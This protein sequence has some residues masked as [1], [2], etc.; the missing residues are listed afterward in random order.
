L[1]RPHI[2]LSA[3]FLMTVLFS[4]PARAEQGETFS[5]TRYEDL[6]SP[7][8]TV[9]DRTV[10]LTPGGL[11]RF[12]SSAESWTV[13]TPGEGLPAEP[14]IGL[15]PTE[16]DLW[17][18]GLGAS[19]SDP[20]FDDWQPYVPDTDY[21]GRFVYDIE[22]DDDYAY[23][24]T[25]AGAARFDRYIL[26]W[27]P[28]A[29]PAERSLGLIYDVAVGEERVWF[30]LE[31]GVAEYRKN[32]ENIRIDTQ[33]GQLT[34]PTVLALRQT[35]S[36]IWAITNEGLARYN[37][38]LETWTSFLPGIDLPDARIH[39]LTLIGQ[40][41]WLGTDDGLWRFSSDT[42][43]WRRDDRC[44]DM[45]GRQV[46][47]FDVKND[48]WAVTDKAFAFYDKGAERWV[49]F[50]ENVSVEPGPDVKLMHQ[51][52]TLFIVTAR[53]ITYA[54]T[55]RENNPTLFIYRTES[56]R[57][58]GVA[59]TPTA[60][61]WRPGLYDSGLGLQKSPDEYLLLKGGVTY[62]L[63]GSDFDNLIDETRLD[64]TLNGRS[65]EGRTLSGYYDTTDPD[66]EAYQISFRGTR[67]D[68]V[69]NISGGEIE[70]QC[71]NS[72]L[73]PDTG[74][75]GGWLRMEAGPRSE[76]TR[77]RL[78]TSDLWA[79]ARRTFPGRKI[80][81]DIDGV[82]ELDHEKL[83]ANSEKIIIDQEILKLGEDYSIDWEHGNF[84]LM[85]HIL[86]DGNTAVEVTYQ[87]EIDDE[88]EAAADAAIPNDRNL[89]AGQIGLAASDRVFM[90][91][92]AASWS[93]TSGNS[94][95][96]IDLNSRIEYKS[97]SSFLRVVPEIAFS[98]GESK[99]GNAA[100][101]ALDGRYRGLELSSR[102]RR[103]GAD[104]ATLEDRLTLLGRLREEATL[105]G[106]FDMS[107]NLQTTLAWKQTHSD[108]V[109]VAT[110][111]DTVSVGHGSESLALA[112]IRFHAS[113]LP[114][115]TM[116]RGKVVVD[117]TGSE[118]TKTISR[119]EMEYTPQP[120]GL[121]RLGIKRLWLRAFFQRSER[122]KSDTPKVTDHTYF[123]FNGSTGKLFSWNLDFENQWI[124]RPDADGPSGLQRNQELN[125][126]LQSEPHSSLSVYFR[127]DSK[128]DQ[129][130]YDYGGASGF[131]TERRFTSNTHFYPGQLTS[132]LSPLTF[133]IDLSRTGSEDGGPGDEL[134]GGDALWQTF[135]AA[136]KGA[137]SNNGVFESRWQIYSWL[138]LID[139]L[140]LTRSHGHED[141]VEFDRDYNL[142]E[143]RIEF[144]PR[145]GQITLR[146]R[147]SGNHETDLGSAVVPEW[148][149]HEYY[150]EWNQTW[151][152]GFQSYCALNFVRSDKVL[153]VHPD[154][155]SSISPIVQGNYFHDWWH[156]D[157]SLTL[158]YTHEYI[159]GEASSF[160]LQRPNTVALTSSV[161]IRPHR[162]LALTLNHTLSIFP[163]DKNEADSDHDFTL[164]LRIR[165]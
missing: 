72:Y 115:I 42:N 10:I 59:A 165:A 41:L 52:D 157:A 3:L 32:A 149:R 45:P 51:H 150:G 113:N 34:E 163:G 147:N 148:F 99:T 19:V 82:E 100:S 136:H 67:D 37:I 69:R 124:H 95:S 145:S 4:T 110:G 8:A 120:D 86:I 48:L 73:N 130:W 146:Y 47:S 94:A 131:K 134:P 78:I 102:Y 96:Q 39:Q 127:A 40:D 129:E 54:L 11:Y 151:G 160:E 132:W 81:Y 107:R 33:L 38:E 126:T 43:I 46:F 101:I 70:Q 77:R 153:Q 58:S 27:E 118:L 114:N 144:R 15:C 5:A 14:L 22:A 158:Q 108:Q 63:Q 98:S 74:I 16:N 56:I 1:T 61:Y 155:K 36:H 18:T 109:P 85:P 28:L 30:A 143:N 24:G 71:F 97:A 121:N 154:V 92:G 112:G 20:Q 128:R 62:D 17:I 60:P 66:N 117:S 23:A 162:L 89:F 135:S 55:N 156:L 139:R 133:Q 152:G 12:L 142:F 90:G 123:R 65:A 2:L 80:F 140:E 122:E 50:T 84:F 35:A 57:Q 79:G 105:D 6:K 119:A 106:R 64:L 29:D 141:E 104:H 68:N 49:E 9:G 164:S 161:Q 137:A 138:R 87:Y 21:P 103:L 83:I 26:E 111:G 93:D 25:D 159:T 116:Q 91:L 75:E 53:K 88:A 31:G 13:L 44:A 125:M 76:S 7:F